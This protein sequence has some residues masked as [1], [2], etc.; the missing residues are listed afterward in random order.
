MFDPRRALRLIA[1]AT[2]SLYSAACAPTA[3]LDATPEAAQLLKTVDVVV[4]EKSNRF[5]LAPAN[6]HRG[7]YYPTGGGLIGALVGGMI[8]GAVQGYQDGVRSHKLR[9][10]S[11]A[12]QADLDEHSVE[13]VLGRIIQENYND[14]AA[15]DAREKST[16]DAIAVLTPLYEFN[17]PFTTLTVT[18]DYVKFATSPEMRR[19]LD[20]DANAN[21]PQAFFRTQKTWK[22]EIPEEKAFKRDENMA[23]WSDDDGAKVK[24]A[25]RSALQYLAADLYAE[26][27][28]PAAT[29]SAATV[30]RPSTSAAD[31]KTDNLF[32]TATA[33]ND[34]YLDTMKAVS[35]KWPANIFAI[36]RTCGEL[37]TFDECRAMKAEA[38]ANLQL[39]LNRLVLQCEAA[40]LENGNA[41]K[42]VDVPSCAELR[43]KTG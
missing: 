38:E 36:I 7:A 18:L 35:A 39:D 2:L 14:L 9:L 10:Q 1:L 23:Y 20:A 40:R 19:V 26:L 22:V 43:Q 34:W 37:G 3:T 5:G 29:L 13:R 17:P 4:L 16:A 28:D 32:A 6:Q 30:S 25:L 11:F 21:T 42:D 33:R 31:R 41:A 8:V 15:E 24:A 12:L 27:T